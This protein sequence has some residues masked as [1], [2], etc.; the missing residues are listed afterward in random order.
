[1]KMVAN[2]VL[3]FNCLSNQHGVLDCQ[4]KL[5]CLKC[6]RRHYTAH[7]PQIEDKEKIQVRSKDM[8]D[9]EDDEELEDQLRNGKEGQSS[10][11]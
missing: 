10:N 9:Y 11:Y 4:S 5:N 1:M 3:C 2:K 7:C 8:V 6:D